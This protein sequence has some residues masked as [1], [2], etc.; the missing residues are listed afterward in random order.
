MAD[1]LPSFLVFLLYYKSGGCFKK[2]QSDTTLSL[3][4]VSA[5]SSTDPLLTYTSILVPHGLKDQLSPVCDRGHDG[6]HGCSH[7]NVHNI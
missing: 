6:I 3:V 4:S 2:L 1:V 7:G 5:F